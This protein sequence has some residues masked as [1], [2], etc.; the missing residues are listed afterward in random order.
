MDTD[1]RNHRGPEVVV[2]LSPRLHSLRLRWAVVGGV[3]LV[4]SVLGIAGGADRVGAWR[5]A[6]EARS[7]ARI[8]RTEV[9]ELRAAISAQ[10]TG[11]RAVLVGGEG[12]VAGFHVLYRESVRTEAETL[13]RLGNHRFLFPDDGLAVATQLDALAAAADRWRSMAA[14]PVLSGEPSITVEEL[15][16]SSDALMGEVDELE[17]VVSAAVDRTAE[18][19]AT[20]ERQTDAVLAACAAAV[21]IGIVVVAVLFRRWVTQPLSEIARAARRMVDD[22]T[23]TWPDATTS[24]LH[25]VTQAVHTLQSALV[26]ERD[27][28]VT[29]LRGLEQSAILALRVRSELANQLGAPPEG[30]AIGSALVPAEGVVAGD[31]FDAGLLD[32]RHLYAIV[33]DVTGHGAHAAL[34]ALKAKS[35]LRAA[36]RSGLTPGDAIAWLARENE[37]DDDIEVMTAVVVVIDI[38]TG[39]CQYAVAGHPP[40]ILIDGVR[41]QP[42]DRTG[43]LIGA[44]PSSWATAQTLIAPGALLLLYTDGVT[45]AMGTDRERFGAERLIE[46]LRQSRVSASE[47]VASVLAAIDGFRTADRSDDVTILAIEHSAQVAVDRPPI[48]LAPTGVELHRPDTIRALTDRVQT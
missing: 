40:P 16:S 44:F 5:D 36:L 6:V 18:R 28:A 20:L 17:R 32:Q 1:R 4:V 42:L 11:V 38:V 43:P 27:R 15:D 45:E 10:V 26:L 39:A 46:S 19:A 31:C 34:D 2:T 12:D 14:A 25:D 24:E 7:E 3:V 41:A 48:S 47:A 29:A 9:A 21:V 13:D 37:R 22:D 30:W 33:I 8:A 35:Q 23:S